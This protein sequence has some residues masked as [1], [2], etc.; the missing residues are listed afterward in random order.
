[1]T[2]KFACYIGPSGHHYTTAVRRRFLYKR[3]PEAVSRERM[4]LKHH[5][6]RSEQVAQRLYSCIPENSWV[7]DVR[8]N[9]PLGGTIVADELSLTYDTCIPLISLRK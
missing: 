3:P 2:L 4:R 1:M 5:E 8:M 7:V 6:W 9:F